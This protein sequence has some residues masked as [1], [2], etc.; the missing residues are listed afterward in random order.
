MDGETV[1]VLAVGRGDRYG[2]WFLVHGFYGYGGAGV[3]PIG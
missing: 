2:G 1:E 3:A